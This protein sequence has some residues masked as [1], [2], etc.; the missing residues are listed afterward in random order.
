MLKGP[1]GSTKCYPREWNYGAACTRWES[2]MSTQ[3]AAPLLSSKD[4]ET[5]EWE[6][7]QGRCAQSLAEHPWGR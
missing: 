3:R 5:G 1:T 7:Y 6:T 2:A 4:F